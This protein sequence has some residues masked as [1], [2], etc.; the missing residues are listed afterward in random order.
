MIYTETPQAPCYSI[1]ENN[2]KNP[3]SITLT[4]AGTFRHGPTT[5]VCLW[6]STTSHNTQP[7]IQKSH[8]QQRAKEPQSCKPSFS[9]DQPRTSSGS[10]GRQP[11]TPIASVV[12]SVPLPN[13]QQI[14]IKW[15][16]SDQSIPINLN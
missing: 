16:T 11:P 4:F 3:L 5:E 8:S 15:R 12:C 1:Q 13:N 9:L 2:F 14:N 7:S 6:S 10:E